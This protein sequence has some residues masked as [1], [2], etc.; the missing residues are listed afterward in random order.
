MKLSGIQRRVHAKQ[1][2]V[3][4]LDAGVGKPRFRL[5]HQR[6]VVRQVV[7]SSSGVTRVMRRPTYR[8]PVRAATSTTCGGVSDSTVR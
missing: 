3:V 2:N 4:H 7:E 6:P 1:L 5:L 8:Y